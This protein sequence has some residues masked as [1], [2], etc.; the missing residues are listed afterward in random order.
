MKNT[1]EIKPAWTRSNREE[2]I[3]L[4]WGILYYVGGEDMSSI[5][6]SFVGF[7]VVSS[8]LLSIYYAFK[9]K[10]QNYDVLQRHDLL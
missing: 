9:D 4:L 3:A 10:D 6:R 1:K 7:M 2:V 8:L 5:A